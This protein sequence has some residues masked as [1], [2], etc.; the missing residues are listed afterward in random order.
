MF[1][2][3]AWVRLSLNCCHSRSLTDHPTG[4][5]ASTRQ[6]F[7]QPPPRPFSRD[8]WWS[9]IHSLGIMSG[10][11]STWCEAEV[12]CVHTAW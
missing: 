6:P 1:R 3:G 2:K 12:R 4:P 11:K 8:A 7:P 10:E 9:C 5:R